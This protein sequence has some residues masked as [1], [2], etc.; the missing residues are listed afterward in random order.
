[1]NDTPIKVLYDGACPLCRREASFWRRMDRGRGRVE[2]EDISAPE[3]E[4]S[5]YGLTRTDVMERIHAI[6]P[7]GTVIEGMEVFRRVYAALGLGWLV[8]PTGWPLLRP[9]FD[10]L[11]AWFARNR[12]R[13]TRRGE[14]C[15][16]C[17]HIS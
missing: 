14:S 4:P 6:L 8:A 13:L 16:A 10:R 7:A 9:V 1:M 5:R 11:Y 17:E 3:F 12:Q 2:L 15:E